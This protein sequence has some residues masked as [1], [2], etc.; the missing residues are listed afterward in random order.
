MKKIINKLND[1]L[2][3]A[4]CRTLAVAES[5][6]ETVSDESGDTNFLSIIIILAIVLA[7]AAIFIIFKDQIIGLVKSAWE[8]FSEAFSN[9]QNNGWQ[10]SSL[11]T[12]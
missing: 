8:T 2:F 6:E 4:Y 9:Q 3:K 12:T 11:P 7:V 5:A 10:P 1:M